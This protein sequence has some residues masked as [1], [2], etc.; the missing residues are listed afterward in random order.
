MDKREYEKTNRRNKEERDKKS[1]GVIHEIGDLG[2]GY[3]E[4]SEKEKEQIQEEK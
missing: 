3:E 4:I 1:I 2:L